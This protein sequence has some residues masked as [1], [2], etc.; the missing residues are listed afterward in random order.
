[1]F[2]FLFLCDLCVFFVFVVL[3]QL[4]GK[5]MEPAFDYFLILD[6]EATCDEGRS[7]GPPEIIEFPTVLFNARTWTVEDEFHHYVK[8]TVNPILTPFCT[9]LTGIQQVHLPFYFT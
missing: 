8:P 5:E 6:F 3:Q 9:E 2:A 4:V 7:F 1:M